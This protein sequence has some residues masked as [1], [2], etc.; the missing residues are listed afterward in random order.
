MVDQELPGPFEY[1]AARLEA[2]RAALIETYP[3]APADSVCDGWG[4]VTFPTSDGPE[5]YA[6]H[7]CRSCRT[8][9]PAPARP[10]DPFARLPL[11]DESEM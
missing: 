2:R 9:Q 7:G 1:V 3:Q 10:A 8:P 6:C 4:L 5:H 11:P